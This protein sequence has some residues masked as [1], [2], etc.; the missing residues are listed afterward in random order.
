MEVF[1]QIAL[2]HA[3]QV[4]RVD[5]KQTKQMVLIVLSDLFQL[6]SLYLSHGLVFQVYFLVGA[7]E[8]IQLLGVMCI[9]FH[10]V[11]FLHLSLSLIDK[12]SSQKDPKHK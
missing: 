9:S 7:V 2:R 8:F 11:P 3:R 4:N 10:L 12:E 6:L 5:E 1:P